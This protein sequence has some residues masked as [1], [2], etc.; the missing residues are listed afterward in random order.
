[1]NTSATYVA[2]GEGKRSTHRFSWPPAHK[3]FWSTSRGAYSARLRATFS[4]LMRPA[5]V[6][7]A[8]RVQNATFRPLLRA[9]QKSRSRRARSIRRLWW[10]QQVISLRWAK[11]IAKMFRETVKKI[12]PSHL[13]T[14]ITTEVPQDKLSVTRVPLWNQTAS[15]AP[16]THGGIQRQFCKISYP[17]RAQLGSEHFLAAPRSTR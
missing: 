15:W 11:P 8:M 7:H 14:F 16:W 13:Y 6:A 17:C 5:M 3:R 12:R 10:T 2:T 9:Y 1:M 4:D